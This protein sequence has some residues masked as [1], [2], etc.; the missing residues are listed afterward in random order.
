MAIKH[1]DW[2]GLYSEKWTGD[3]NLC[4]MSHPAKFARGLIQKIY[5]HAMEEGWITKNSRIVDCFGGVALGGFFALAYD[6]TWV[7][8]ELEQH[9]VDHGAGCECTGVTEEDWAA[10]KS[11]LETI[12]FADGRHICPECIRR[13][14]EPEPAATQIS[15]FTVNTNGYHFPPHHYIGNIEL[16]RS[17]GL[18][19]GSATLL[20]GDSRKLREVL[21][22]KL[23]ADSAISSPP[24][25]G[26]TA[27]QGWQLLGK[28]AQEGKLTVKQ[29]NGDTNKLY[30]SWSPD[31]DT[32]YGK[33][34]GQLG[35]MPEGE[36][37]NPDSIG[38]IDSVDFC[39]DGNIE[40]ANDLDPED[41]ERVREILKNDPGFHLVATSPPFIAQSGGTNVTSKEGPLADGRLLDR[42]SAGNSAA[43]GYGD[44]EQNLANL[45]GEGFDQVIGSPPYANQEK[46]YGDRPNRW[47]KVKDNP[48]FA[49]RT[50][51]ANNDRPNEYGETEGQLE[52]MTNDGFDQVIGS[53]PFADSLSRDRVDPDGRRALA[54]SQGISNAEFISPIDMENI[55]ERSQQSGATPGNLG[56][57]GDE[58]FQMAVTSPAYGEIEQS[59]SDKGLKEHGTGLTGGERCFSEY[60]NAPGQL[61]RMKNEGYD[62][63]LSSPPYAEA[64]I[65]Q[66]SGQ[67]QCGHHDAYGE[68]EGQLGAMKGDGYDG[69][70]TSPPFEAV[71]SDRP[72][73]SIVEGGLRM[74]A[75]SM[76]D[77]YGST[78]GQLGSD[79][80]ETFWSAARKIL[81][82]L[83]AVLKPNGKAIFVVKSYVKGGA[84]VPFP[85]QWMKL[86]EVVGFIPLHWHRAWVVEDKG[87]QLTLEGEAIKKQ[88]SRKSFFRRLYENKH[89]ENAIDYECVI[90]LEKPGLPQENETRN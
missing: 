16:W 64:R 79:S 10:R 75:S 85:E 2:Y 58:G 36:P 40:W 70:L 61:G 46:G 73:A 43:H 84:I 80:G 78:E 53:P 67:E 76:G 62:Q 18:K 55:G 37:P 88:T 49:G 39:V 56:G 34:P 3:I 22:D 20:Q 21:R 12:R 38:Y 63:I 17:K 72:S 77:G 41:V 50:H 26:V 25:T 11:D 15:M 57:M 48:N 5:Q 54:R 65:G 90:C 89:P 74:G 47:D 31:R 19:L 29:V 33:A 32:S 87:T 13:S 28:Y 45:P 4:S 52:Q 51:W 1:D 24:F 42:H 83:Y 14:K 6:M 82:E 59:G 60:G 71:T 44:G 27:D 35:D 8:V 81:E 23:S 86:C 69:C 9:H 30:P 66:E 7:G 68:N